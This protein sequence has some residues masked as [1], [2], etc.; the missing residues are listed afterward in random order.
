MLLQ[1][2]E[3]LVGVDGLYQIVGYL[4]ADGLVHDVLL[5][6]FGNHDYRDVGRRLFDAREGFEAGESGHVLVEDYKVE[7]L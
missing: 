1:G 2:D 7:V 4:V 6:A 3:N 5:L